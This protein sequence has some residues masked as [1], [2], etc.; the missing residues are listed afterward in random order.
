MTVTDVPPD[1]L[2]EGGKTPR[3]LRGGGTSVMTSWQ[4]ENSE[5]VQSFDAVLVTTEPGSSD[6]GKHGREGRV[7]AGVGVYRRRADGIAPSPLPESS[8]AAPEKN[9]IVIP[10]TFG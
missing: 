2:P 3:T 4:A 9:S 6:D 1:A 8:H 5:V 7:T 10:V